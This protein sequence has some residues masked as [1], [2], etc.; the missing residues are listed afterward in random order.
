MAEGAGLAFLIVVLIAIILGYDEGGGGC[1]CNDHEDDWLDNF[2]PEERAEARAQADAP[3]PP[4]RR[5]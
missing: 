3:D 4:R 2:P 5:S 1:S